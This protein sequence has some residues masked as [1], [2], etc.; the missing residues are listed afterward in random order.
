MVQPLPRTSVNGGFAFLAQAALCFFAAFTVKSQLC[1][2]PVL[3]LP[4]KCFR[5]PAA[6]TAFPRHFG[7]T[8]TLTPVRALFSLFPQQQSSLCCP[9]LPLNQET[10]SCI[11]DIQMQ[12]KASK[13]FQHCHRSHSTFSKSKLPGTQG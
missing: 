6:R 5:A 12:N 2:K 8:A 10:T 9:L 7:S 4:V 1:T 13:A 3:Q 11:Q